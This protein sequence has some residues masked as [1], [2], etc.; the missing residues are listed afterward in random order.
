MNHDVINFATHHR[1]AI[2]LATPRDLRREMA[3]VYRDARAG[4]IEASEATRLIYCLREI[5]RIMF[6]EQRFKEAQADNGVDGPSQ[7]SLPAARALVQRMVEEIQ[8]KA[9][10]EAMT[11][12]GHRQEGQ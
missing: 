7:G 11:D 4:R 1:R 6:V 2:D 12:S 9:E 3:S 10:A 5:A 8:A